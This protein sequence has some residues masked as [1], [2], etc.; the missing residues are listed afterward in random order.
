MDDVCVRPRVK[1]RLSSIQ[2]V[3]FPSINSSSTAIEQNVLLGVLAATPLDQYTNCPLL[4]LDQ[5]LL[6]HHRQPQHCHL[7]I[8]LVTLRIR[9]KE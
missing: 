6:L 4:L 8:I 3:R 1:V 5:R 2:F 7:N 9:A